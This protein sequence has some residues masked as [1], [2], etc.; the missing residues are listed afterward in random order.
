MNKKFFLLLFIF[1]FYPQF[2]SATEPEP[3][4]AIQIDSSDNPIILGSEESPSPTLTLLDAL[5]DPEL[6]ELS[7]IMHTDNNP[8]EQTLYQNIVNRLQELN[9]SNNLSHLKIKFRSDLASF[10]K[11]IFKKIDDHNSLVA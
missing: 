6:I 5:A 3:L 7:F 10:L 4:T 9:V 8:E 2:S 11:K 1:G